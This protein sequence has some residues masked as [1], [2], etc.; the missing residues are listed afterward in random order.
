MGCIDVRATTDRPSQCLHKLYLFVPFPVFF[1]VC[2]DQHIDEFRVT[3]SS[4]L[5]AF[6]QLVFLP[7]VN[8]SNMS[9][10]WRIRPQFVV[11]YSCEGRPL[12]QRHRFLHVVTVYP[13]HFYYYCRLLY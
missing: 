9:R 5:F 11:R 7:P 2:T 6:F 13:R 10:I 12:I 4:F 1:P 3:D 8:G